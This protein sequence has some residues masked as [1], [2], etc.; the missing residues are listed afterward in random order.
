MAKKHTSLYID[1]EL[2]ADAQR[3]I[4]LQKAPGVHDVACRGRPDQARQVGQAGQNTGSSFYLVAVHQSQTL[5]Q[6]LLRL[7]Q[8][9]VPQ[10]VIRPKR[11]EPHQIVQLIQLFELRHCLSVYRGRFLVTVHLCES[12]AHLAQQLGSE[13]LVGLTPRAI[14]GLAC[15]L[16]SV[17]RLACKHV[18]TREIV[19]G[20]Q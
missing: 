15:H 18:K 20:G 13:E 7:F 3:L 12:V 5:I 4:R 6:C 16:Q 8:V 10:I 11:L 2:L 19:S 14:Q 1:E 9:P 17:L